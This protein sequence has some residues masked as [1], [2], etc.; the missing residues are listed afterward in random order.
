ME[1]DEI[2]SNSR[3]GGSEGRRKGKG[4]AKDNFSEHG[5]YGG[6]ATRRVT[7]FLEAAIKK[8]APKG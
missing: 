8:K 3:K 7:E 2:F 4:K 5:K 6:K 1:K